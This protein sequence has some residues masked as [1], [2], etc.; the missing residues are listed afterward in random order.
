[1]VKKTKQTKNDS[2]LKWVLCRGVSA[3]LVKRIG[4]KSQH[5]YHT[6]LVQMM[7]LWYIAVFA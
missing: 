7:S 6:R 1:M 3:A 5:D 2:P 4:Y